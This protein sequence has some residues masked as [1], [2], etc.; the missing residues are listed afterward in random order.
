[1]AARVKSPVAAIALALVSLLSWSQTARAQDLSDLPTAA[2]VPP[3][4]RDGIN[5]Q[6]PYW[7]GSGQKRFFASAVLELGGIR[8]QPTLAVGYGKPH[9]SWIG[10]ETF[11]SLATGGGRVYGGGRGVLPGFRPRVG[12]RYEFP[13]NQYFLPKQENYDRFDL[14]TRASQRSRYIAAEAELTG[15]LPIPHGSLFA[16]ATG[17]YLT[18]I[19]DEYNVFEQTLRVVTAPGWM[20]RGRAGYLAHFGYGDTFRFGAAIE[21]IGLLGRDNHI[22]RAGPILSVSLTHHMEATGAVMVVARSAD[23]LGLEGADLGQIGLRYRWST[24]D[25]WPEFP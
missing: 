15:A 16:V 12:A 22:V 13:V 23:T 9:W 6:Q 21:V 4:T 3:A 24:G 10:L 1:M 17:Y 14:E 5:A 2:S 18:N 11:T 25:R 7:Q 8:Y 20:W 19:P